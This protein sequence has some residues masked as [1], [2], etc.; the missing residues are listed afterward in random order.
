[1]VPIPLCLTLS[2]SLASQIRHMG[3]DD[4]SGG[5]EVILTL[6]DRGI[7]DDKGNLDDDDG[8][9]ENVRMA[10]ERKRKN[11]RERATRVKPLWEEDGKRRGILDK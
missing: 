6:V 9:L 7:L 3:V 11:A 8:E 4:I 10:E 5:D 1:M 2:D